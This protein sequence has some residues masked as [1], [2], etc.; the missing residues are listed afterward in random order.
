MTCESLKHDC[1]VGVEGIRRF[2]KQVDSCQSS[3]L[4][5]GIVILRV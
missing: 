3:E 5:D 4:G 2:Q 1:Y